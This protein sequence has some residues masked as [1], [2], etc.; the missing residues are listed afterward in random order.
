MKVKRGLIKGAGTETNDKTTLS[1]DT[2]SEV[3]STSPGAPGASPEAAASIAEPG[4]EP[5]AEAQAKLKADLE[6]RERERERAREAEEITK[7]LIE[8]NAFM[9]EFFES[10]DDTNKVV[11]EETKFPEYSSNLGKLSEKII[12]ADRKKHI[13]KNIL[14]LD[15][16]KTFLTKILSS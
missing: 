8:V 12:N 4:A 5:G 13:M 1:E 7:K 10:F 9:K 15:N 11:V 2:K 16:Y 14:I 3:A 6:A